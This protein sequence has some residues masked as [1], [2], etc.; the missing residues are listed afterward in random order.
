MLIK[1]DNYDILTVTVND[2]HIYA[3]QKEVL[4]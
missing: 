3:Y 4:L 1:V 2:K